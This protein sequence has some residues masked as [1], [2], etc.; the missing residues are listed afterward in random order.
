MILQLAKV[1]R[2]TGVTIEHVRP[3]P[4]LSNAPCNIVVW[5][6]DESTQLMNLTYSIATPSPSVQT[7]P[8]PSSTPISNLRL[9]ISSN[10]GHTEYSDRTRQL[11]GVDVIC[12]R[13]ENY[14]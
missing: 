4:D 13:S 2:I 1:V 9:E 5:D 12:D 6:N 8:M 7:F 11:C 14:L 10:W 3:S